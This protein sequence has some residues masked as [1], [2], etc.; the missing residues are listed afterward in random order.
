MPNSP[1][2]Q[3]LLLSFFT[4]GYNVLEAVV[5]ILAAWLSGSN[6]LWG[7]G[8]DSVIESLSG[9]VMIWRFWKYDLSPESDEEFER[10]ESKAAR[11]VAVT[12]FV[13]GAYVVAT[14]GYSLYQGQ[15]PETSLLGIAL[16]VASLVVMPVLF[17]LKYRLGKAIGSRS[18]VADAKETLACVLLSVALLIGLGINYLWQIWWIDSAAALVLAVLIIREGFETLEECECAEDIQISR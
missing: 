6:A 2:T 3:A 9:A 17:L 7:F 18:L 5:A 10:V 15:A 12:F 4:V 1:R 8:L 16:A 13:L 14:A 11:L